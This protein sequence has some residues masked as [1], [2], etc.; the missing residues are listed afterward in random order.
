MFGKLC[1]NDDTNTP[2]RLGGL[3]EVL[4]HL[5]VWLA[6]KLALVQRLDLGNLPELMRV[7]LARLLGQRR[8]SP[9]YCA[10]VHQRAFLIHQLNFHHLLHSDACSYE[11]I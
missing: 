11:Q 5:G 1:Y 7:V 6:L 3:L 10:I 4:N 9:S 8:V 2:Q